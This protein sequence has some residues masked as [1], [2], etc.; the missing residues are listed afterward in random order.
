MNYFH[1]WMQMLS[2]IVDRVDRLESEEICS[3]LRASKTLCRI[4]SKRNFELE[5]LMPSCSV[6]LN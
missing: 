6:L 5:W 3:C 1:S 2:Q 4:A